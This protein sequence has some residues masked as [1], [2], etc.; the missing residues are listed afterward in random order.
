M[1]RTG[2]G[3]STLADLLMGLIEPQ[4]GSI[5][6]DGVRLE[7][8]SLQ[9][10]RRCVAHVPQMLFLADTSIARNIAFGSTSAPDPDRLRAA[11]AAAHIHAFIET[12]PDGYETRIGEG[13]IRLS[14]GQRQRLAIARAF[15]RDLPFLV[16]DE[17]TSALDEDSERDV[18][19]ALDDIQAKGKTILLVTHRQ[20]ALAGC[21]RIVSVVDG[22]AMEMPGAGR[23]ADIG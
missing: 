20:S 23:R 4:A 5:A 13:G 17:A 22:V 7:G 10:W 2:S 1:G 14:G 21:N 12:L 18:L 19:A 16:L 3:K 15:Y 11:A 9:R 8:R 6:V